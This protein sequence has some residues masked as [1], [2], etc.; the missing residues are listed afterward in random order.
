MAHAGGD[1]AGDPGDWALGVGKSRWWWLQS[2]AWSQWMRG[3]C[4]GGDIPDGPAVRT[5]SRCSMG[6]IPGQG[7]SIFFNNNKTVVVGDPSQ[8]RG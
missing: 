8:G 2:P 1:T 3:V 7:M 5:C 6:S 4:R